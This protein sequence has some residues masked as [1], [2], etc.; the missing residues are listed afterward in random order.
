MTLD[1]AGVWSARE[2]LRI[3]SA[4]VPAL[5]GKV[6][7][8]ATGEDQTPGSSEAR[9]QGSQESHDR[10]APPSTAHQCGPEAQLSGVCDHDQGSARSVD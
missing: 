10:Y 4:T 8:G 5:P 2:L 1:Q 6:L 9:F 3:V 7:R